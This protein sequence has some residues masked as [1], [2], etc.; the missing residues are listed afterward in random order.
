MLSPDGFVPGTSDA[1]SFCPALF[2]SCLLPESFLTTS[3]VVFLI[4]SAV[5]SPEPSLLTSVSWP[6]S[7]TTFAVPSTA[8][9]LTLKPPS[10]VFSAVPVTLTTFPAES[11]PS[12]TIS[13]ASLIVAS[14]V[15]VTV[16]PSA[17]LTCICMS[18]AFATVA[19]SVDCSIFPAAVSFFAPQAVTAANDNTVSPTIIYFL[20]LSI[21]IITTPSC[22]VLSDVTD[23]VTVLVSIPNLLLV[24]HF[25]LQHNHHIL[26]HI[27]DM[28]YQG[29]P[30]LLFPQSSLLTLEYLCL[31]TLL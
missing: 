7:A 18:F 12:N 6:L 31:L 20:I 24:L 29:Y 23:S 1:L 5:I 9:S 4:S 15:S 8:A 30:H 25:F 19:L 28:D 14:P 3:V 21:I 13:P 22:Q 27:R 11:F 26:S 2:V 17:S 10:S 16:L